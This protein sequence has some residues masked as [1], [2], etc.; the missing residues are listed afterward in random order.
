MQDILGIENEIFG[1]RE[2]MNECVNND[3]NDN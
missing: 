2:D 1:A 3:K